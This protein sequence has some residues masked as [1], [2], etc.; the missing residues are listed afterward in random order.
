MVPSHRVNGNFQH[1]KGGLTFVGFYHNSAPVETA[2]G[3]SVMRQNRFA[4]L[5]TRA[6]LS[7]GER[8]V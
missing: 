6:P 1:R 2:A 5:G 8:I 7:R 4:A 3:A